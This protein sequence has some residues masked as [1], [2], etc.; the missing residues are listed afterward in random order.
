MCLGAYA[1]I[2]SF[3]HS[4]VPQILG[5][6]DT[7]DNEVSARN[8]PGQRH[9]CGLCLREPIL[10]WAGIIKKQVNK[11]DSYRLRNL[12]GRESTGRRGRDEQWWAEGRDPWHENPHE[13]SHARAQGNG[14]QRIQNT[15]PVCPE[16]RRLGVL[17]NRKK[18]HV[19]GEKT[20]VREAEDETKT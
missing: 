10:W 15:K 2:H 6:Y 18:A 16:R 14:M 7:L 1:L 4:F 19:A 11:Q 9:R 8:A 5:A 13:T 3:I 17:R 20:A 12:P